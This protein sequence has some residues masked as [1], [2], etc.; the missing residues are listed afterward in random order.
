MISFDEAPLRTPLWCVYGTEFWP[1]I[2]CCMIN[3]PFGQERSIWGYSVYRNS[4][5]F[6]T[7]GQNES[8]IN[9]N[10]AKLFISQEDALEYLRK[11]TTPKKS[12][13]EKLNQKH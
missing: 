13:I 10:N 7:L 3:K 5:A 9:T 1:S 2:I 6:R 11:L 8:W 12:A 4:P